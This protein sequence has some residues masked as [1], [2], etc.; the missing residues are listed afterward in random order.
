MF[1]TCLTFGPHSVPSVLYCK[2][3][4][5]KSIPRSLVR[6]NYQTSHQREVRLSFCAVLS[7]LIFAVHVIW[8]SR[9]HFRL[10]GCHTNTHS[11]TRKH[12]QS[13][14]YCTAISSIE[15]KSSYLKSAIL[16]MEKDDPVQAKMT[17]KFFQLPTDI[18][19]TFEISARSGNRLEI[20]PYPTAFPYGNGMVLHFYQ[21][22]ESSTTKTVHKII[23]KGLKTYV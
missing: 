16:V 13:R 22:Q 15:N 21:Q 4:I 9:I 19:T 11:H 23:N 7:S 17:R 20:N 12:T 5:Q 1:H 2:C 10:S 8:R 18:Y 3:R 6:G 14:G